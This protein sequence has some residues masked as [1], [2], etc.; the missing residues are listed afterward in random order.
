MGI[1]RV[2]KLISVVT[3]LLRLD[4]VSTPVVSDGFRVTRADWQSVRP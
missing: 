4:W 3:Q 1:E 2:V